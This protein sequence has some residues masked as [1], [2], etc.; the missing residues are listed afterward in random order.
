MS[1]TV[2]IIAE[3]QQ[4]KFD[5]ITFEMLGKGRELASALGSE[6]VAVLAGHS[7]KDM[8]GQLG[9]ASRV[10]CI[11][12]PALAN[13][14]PEAYAKTISAVISAHN[15]RVVLTGYTSIGM[16]IGPALSV[17]NQLPL[18]SF[19]SAITVGGGSMSAVSQLYGGKMN[20]ESVVEGGSAVLA[21]LPGMFPAEAGKQSGSPAVEDFAAPDLGGLSVTFRKLIAPEAGDVDITAQ[22]VLVSVGR[23]IQSDENLPIVNDL[24]AKLGGAVSCSRPLVDSKWMPKT[25]QVGKSGLKVKPR[26]YLA[27][28]ISGAPEH[29]EGMKD[30]GLI[31]AVNSDPKAPI[32]DYAHYGVVG[33]LFDLIPAMSEKL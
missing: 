32:F 17:R 28:G 19:V 2:F 29:I 8:A 30:A 4:G 31:I 7:V 16:E 21:I 3:Q 12:S 11:D 27:L 33:D 6:V 26:L 15:P 10:I 13:F 24:A 1:N 5:D 20:V 22:D 25:R 9:A 18:V 14:S 23:G